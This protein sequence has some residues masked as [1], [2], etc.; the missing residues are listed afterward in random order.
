MDFSEIFNWIFSRINRFFNRFKLKNY[1]KNFFIKNGLANKKNP[2]EE[3]KRNQILIEKIN[4][5]DSLKEEN[6][7]TIKKIEELEFPKFDEDVHNDQNVEEILY[8]VRM[9]KSLMSDEFKNL[10]SEM[11]K[12]NIHKMDKETKD[13]IWKKLRQVQARESYDRKCSLICST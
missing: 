4:E 2:S 7:D 6:T 8:T 13:K 11:E 12:V 10:V 5:F 3:L 9:T 1:A